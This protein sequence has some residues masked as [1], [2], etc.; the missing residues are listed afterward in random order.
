MKLSTRSRY[1]LKAIVDIAAQNPFPTTVKNIASRQNIPQN[2]LEQIISLLKKAG[3]VKSIRGSQGGYI[4][5]CNP[6][7]TTVG[8]I[9]RTLEGSL[10]PV[11]CLSNA[12]DNSCKTSDCKYC[13]TKSVWMKI[14]ENISNTIDSITISNLIDDYK[15]LSAMEGDFL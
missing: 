4:I 15:K 11:E 5:N 8:D 12:A 9:L 13:F 7:S 1:G 2:Y 14:H 6:D 3:F 10:Y